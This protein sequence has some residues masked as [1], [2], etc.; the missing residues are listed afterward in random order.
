M[1]PL[2][3]V[4]AISFFS[5][6][7]L[8]I[9]GNSLLLAL[10]SWLAY[11]GPGLLT[12]EV[13]LLNL[14]TANLVMAMTRGLPNSLYILGLPNVFNDTQCRLLVY[15]SRISRAMSIC[16][17]CLLSCFQCVTIMSTSVSCMQVK[18]R[19]QAYVGLIIVLL[20]MVNATICIMP[21]IYAVSGTNMTNLEYSF[22]ISYCIV[23]VPD[24]LSFL[25]NS[26]ALFARDLV[27]VVGMSFASYAILYALYKHG[28]QVKT[29]RSSERSQSVSAEARAS[30]T[31]STLVALYVLFFG[32]DNSIW[33]YQSTAPKNIL[34]SI[35]DIRY[36]FSVCYTSVFPFVILLFNR[37][38][39]ETIRGCTNEK[40]CSMEGITVLTIVH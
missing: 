33:F 38:L 1:D 32:I 3:I 8:G 5:M 37:K 13:I 35:S 21:L 24:R 29:I 10:F 26:F 14:T 28:K 12:S 11:Q 40:A 30:K 7:V 16:L 31:V 23:I 2:E 15:V 17:T 36:F 27:F 22:R 20:L 34:T 25:S 39:L 19:I 18:V 9:C 4:R 6:T